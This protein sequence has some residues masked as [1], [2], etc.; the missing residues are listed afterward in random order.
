M[1]RLFLKVGIGGLA[2]VL[3]CFAVFLIP[4]MFLG[5][6][7]RFSHARNMV[8]SGLLVA[9]DVLEAV[10]PDEV[11]RAF[12]DMRVHFGHPVALVDA[13]SEQL[14]A[15]LAEHAG[16]REPVFLE[17]WDGLTAYVSLR[18]GTRFLVMG[19]LPDPTTLEL[20]GFLVVFATILA[21]ILLFSVLLVLPIVRRLAALEAATQ[22]MSHGDLKVRVR[23]DSP[24]A[25]G[26]LAASFNGMAD[27]LRELFDEREQLLQAVA[28][29]IGTPLSRMRFGLE[30]LASTDDPEARSRR[31]AALDDELTELDDLT[32]ELTQWV[33]ADGAPEQ[34]KPV[35]VADCLVSLVELV[36]EETDK[37]VELRLP[38]DGE[39]SVLAD[40]RQFQ[41]A[42]ENLIRNGVR[43]CRGQV[44]VEVTEEGR[45]V[46]VEVRD[47]GP[48]IPEA[49]RG[50]IFDPFVR[51]DESRDRSEGGL[52]LGLAIVH[53]IARRYSGEAQVTTAPEGGACF[54]T[55]WPAPG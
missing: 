11:D 8:D 52:G 38:R 21:V 51:L 29:E 45:H 55:R 14:P 2:M 30:L 20:S 44:V 50:R 17:A 32:S 12:T 27:R 19:P 16:E 39:A 33:Q 42:I 24:D 7:P 40:A 4:F 48:V 25:V 5:Q 53:R 36:S 3:V 31:L 41:R 37:R 26:Q 34:A 43:H 15:E 22:R 28:H 10:P 49:D 1:K 35:K 46:R 9:R 23:D 13:G 18:D 6:N 47:D 54:V